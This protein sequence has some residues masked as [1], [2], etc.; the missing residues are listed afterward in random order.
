[1]LLEGDW[2]CI[3]FPVGTK[4]S[5]P[6]ILFLISMVTSHDDEFAQQVQYHSFEVNIW[7]PLGLLVYDFRPNGSLDEYLYDD[8]KA[9]NA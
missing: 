5:I 1:M 4:L 9:N 7:Y 6:L 8:T 3:Y 2:R